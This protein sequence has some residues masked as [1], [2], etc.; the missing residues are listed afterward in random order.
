MRAIAQHS[1]NLF[2]WFLYLNKFE[3]Q[4]KH[5]LVYYL[6]ILQT[7]LTNWKRPKRHIVHQCK[8]I[9]YFCIFIF[10]YYGLVVHNS[11]YVS[12]KDMVNINILFDVTFVKLY[13]SY[14]LMW[15]SYCFQLRFIFQIRIQVQIAN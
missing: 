9:Q 8:L 5:Q 1:T 10:C 14:W 6:V 12:A 13:K 4:S 11:N 3:T 7:L 2:K 15:T